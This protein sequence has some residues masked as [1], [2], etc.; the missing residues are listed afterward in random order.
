LI[1]T[2][3]ELLSRRVIGLL[4]KG[5]AGR[6]S[7]GAAMAVLAARRDMRTLVMET[8]PQT[9]IAASYGIRAGC[10]PS[11]LAPSLWAM[12]LGGRESLEEY[13]GKVV[14]RP[15]LR[16]VLASSLYDYFV[17][18][19]PA[20]RELTMMGK[21]YHE[22]VR[23]PRNEPR[24]DIIVLDA[25]A[26]GKALSMLG[27]PFAARDIFG[28]SMVGSEADEVAEFFRDSALCAMVAVTTAEPLAI[29]ESLEFN[30]ELE[31]LG[32][33]TAAIILNRLSL[34][35]FE[36]A[37]IVRMLRRRDRTPALEHLAG[38]AEIARAGLRKRNRE[39]R[40]LDILRRQIGAPV[41]QLREHRGLVSRALATE[42]AGDLGRMASA[43]PVS[44][45]NARP[46][47][48]PDCAT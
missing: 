4:G 27:M 9:P 12:F 19:A 39:R 2:L 1:N 6:T 25:P 20:V 13:L 18:A 32:L 45:A 17:R 7:V 37:D 11:E 3:D 38:L 16:A 23:R 35:A 36:T 47:Q 24:W 43:T 26:S 14:P 22:I 21:V 10:A 28:A 44:P 40:V 31:R 34:A 33:K 8:D 29:S 15:L 46:R 30:R 41:V 42:L 5:G 48:G